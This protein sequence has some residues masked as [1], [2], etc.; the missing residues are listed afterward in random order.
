VFFVF[1]IFALVMGLLS[2]TA[3]MRYDTQEFLNTLGNFVFSSL[4]VP[5]ICIFAYYFYA[6]ISSDKSG[7][8]ISFLRKPLYI[9]WDNIVEIRPLKP[10]LV[11]SSWIGIKIFPNMKVTGFTSKNAVI[12]KRYLIV[13][14]DKLTFIHRLYG[15]FLGRT[16]SASFLITS[17][18]SQF[19]AL[20]NILEERTQKETKSN[21]LTPRLGGS[22]NL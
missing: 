22:K 9:D 12:E 8:K 1:G 17:S 19:P 7:L 10:K 15:I 2:L 4:L 6:D 14:K 5:A 20:M 21:N 16:L 11:L 3:I 18:I 13:T